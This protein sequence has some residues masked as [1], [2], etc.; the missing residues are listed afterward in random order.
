[1]KN[2]IL[3]V[4][5]V[6]NRKHLVSLAIKSALDQTLS[7]EHWAHLIID[8]DSTDGADEICQKWA[9]Q[10]SHIYFCKMGKNL[11]QMGAY[12][13]ALKWINEEHP[14][15]TIMAQLDS[16]DMLAPH[17]LQSIYDTFN[18]HPDIGMTYS[19]FD[20]IGAAPR[21]KL[22]HKAHPK[23]KIAPNQL[24]LEGQRILRNM[25]IKG[26]VI[27]HMRALSVKCLNDIGGFDESYKYST[28]FN[29]AC[30]MIQ[31]FP[32]IKIT[33]PSLYHWREHGD[34]VQGHASPE[35]TKNWQD[36][37]KLY[38]KKWKKEGLL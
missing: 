11:H 5:L 6:R 4:S 16:D 14:E 17:A 13:W 20:I 26:N 25:Q 37:V 28:D 8:N 1:M 18:K 24:T 35:Q 38:S 7:K 27:G 29:M 23:A 15:F 36:M 19:N 33:G 32:V 21:N 10:H 22:K 34:Q 2:K 3:L 30:K 12:N 31:S 9:D